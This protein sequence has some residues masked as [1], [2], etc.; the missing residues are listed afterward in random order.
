MSFLGQKASFYFQKLFLSVLFLIEPC[1][2]IESLTDM[3]KRERLTQ[4]L[5]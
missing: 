1:L 3:T 2:I 4:S 5:R